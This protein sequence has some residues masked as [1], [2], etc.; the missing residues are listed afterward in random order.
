MK[1]TQDKSLLIVI[2]APSGA[3][4]STL[5]EMLLAEF[6]NTVYSISC[7]TRPPRGTEVDGQDYCFLAPE[8]FEDLSMHGEFLEQAVV[9]GHR[10]GTLYKAVGDALSLHKDVLMDIDVQGARQIR[11]KVTS[12]P[13]DSVLKEAFVDIF[14]EPPSQDTL[15]QRL[16]AR[17]EDLPD[18]VAGRMA[19]AE[20]EMACADEFGYRIVNDNLD[21][22]YRDLKSIIAKA[23]Y[24]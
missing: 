21:I 10:Y 15:R 3:G 23:R 24:E 18:A 7:T 1:A 16:V 2:A 20:K 13:V 19:T 11:A 6:K 9:H 4:K 5:C 14:I 22:A 12:D 17:N 8:D